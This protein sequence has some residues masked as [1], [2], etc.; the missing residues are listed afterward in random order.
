MVD[1]KEGNIKEVARVFHMRNNV[2]N[3]TYDILPNAVVF[4]SNGFFLA[5]FDY[6]G[7]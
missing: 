3:I 4:Y 6:G 2:N 1:W 7:N 5:Y